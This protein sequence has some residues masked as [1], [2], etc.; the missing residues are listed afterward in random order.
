MPHFETIDSNKSKCWRAHEQN[1]EDYHIYNNS[2][3]ISKQ[4]PVTCPEGGCRRIQK[5]RDLV[6]I[7]P[8]KA[9]VSKL[10]HMFV[11]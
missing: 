6:D 5:W 10:N 1:Y 3:T 2:D 11:V 9:R 4:F 7:T 8:Q